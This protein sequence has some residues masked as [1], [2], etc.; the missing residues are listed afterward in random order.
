M[1]TRVQILDE[2]DCISHSTN[3]LEKNCLGDGVHFSLLTS[4]LDEFIWWPQYDHTNKDIFISMNILLHISLVSLKFFLEFTIIT[5]F[6]S[7]CVL[8][9]A[10]I[11]NLLILK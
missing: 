9:S 5:T 3:T 7:T 4:Y 11:N 10:K 6:V 1:A 8:N 2:T